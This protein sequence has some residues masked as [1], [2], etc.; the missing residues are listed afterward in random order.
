MNFP[1]TACQNSYFVYCRCYSQ[2]LCTSPAE[3]CRFSS[4]MHES[5]NEDGPRGA[6]LMA[7]GPGVCFDTGHVLKLCEDRRREG[8]GGS[9]MGAGGRRSCIFQT[10]ATHHGFVGNPAGQVTECAE[11]E[12]QK[13][14]K[15]KERCFWNGRGRLKVPHRLSCIGSPEV[16]ANLDSC[17][18]FLL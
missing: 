17:S 4:L 1:S 16:A 11:C 15:K 13:K 12:K 8:N 6:T 7:A 10:H 9:L 3:W 5:V 2:I 14:Q 18:S